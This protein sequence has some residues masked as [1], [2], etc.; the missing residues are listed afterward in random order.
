[1]NIVQQAAE[2]ISHE[3]TKQFVGIQ[4]HQ[5]TFATLVANIQQCVNEIGVAMFRNVD[6]RS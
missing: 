3:M 4:N 5:L 6:S 2:K 1:M